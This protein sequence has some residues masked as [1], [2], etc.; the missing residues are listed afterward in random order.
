MCTRGFVYPQ[1][2]PVNDVA[3]LGAAGMTGSGKC[4]ET[5]ASEVVNPNACAVSLALIYFADFF[6]KTCVLMKIN[7]HQPFCT[8]FPIMALLFG[9]V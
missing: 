9:S 1:E 2:I 4:T 7:L 5:S 6:S 8:L 3:N